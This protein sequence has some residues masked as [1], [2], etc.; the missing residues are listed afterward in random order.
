MNV[1]VIGF[2]SGLLVIL[3][4]IPYGI[5]TYQTKVKPN[6]TSW[7]LWTLIGF[8]LLLTYESSGA[9][10]NIWPAISGFTNPLLITLLILWRHGGWTKPNQIEIACIV[11][12]LLSLG[13]W[14]MVRENKQMAQYALYLAIIADLFAA[15]PTIIFVWTKPNADRPFAWVLFA[16]GYG[17]AI[18]AITEHT[19]A[20]YILPAYMFLCSFIVSTPLVLYRWQQKSPLSEWV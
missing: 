9:G 5:R 6:L 4:A 1:E 12:G 13:L 17:L 2:V 10:A 11:F 3:S 19:L 7:I 14:L 18:F 15:I 8:T 16:I 20:N